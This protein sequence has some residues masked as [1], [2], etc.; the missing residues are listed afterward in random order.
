MFKEITTSQHSCLKKTSQGALH[1]GKT[2]SKKNLEK[3]KKWRETS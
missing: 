2:H 3:K 1:S